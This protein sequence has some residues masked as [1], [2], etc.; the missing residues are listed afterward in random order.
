MPATPEIVTDC[1]RRRKWS[2]F[3]KRSVM[4]EIDEPASSRARAL[5]GQTRGGGNQDLTCHEEG[6][7]SNDGRMVGRGSWCALR[8]VLRSRVEME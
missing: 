6:T 3:A 1:G 8:L 5:D 4:K 2:D 7:W